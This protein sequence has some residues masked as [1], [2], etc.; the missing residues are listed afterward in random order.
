M[1]T[2]TPAT[3]ERIA[4]ICNGLRDRGRPAPAPEQITPEVLQ[5]MATA[6]A[7]Y[8]R[9]YSSTIPQGDGHDEEWAKVYEAEEIARKNPEQVIWNIAPATLPDW[10]DDAL[11]LMQR[12]K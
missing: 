6:H 11:E 10:Y 7:E 4:Y 9:R 2:I 1:I 8:L 3:A 12:N 5:A